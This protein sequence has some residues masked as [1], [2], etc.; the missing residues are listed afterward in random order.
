MDIRPLIEKM[1]VKE[2]EE[3]SGEPLRWGVELVLRRA[4]GRTAKPIEIIGT[5]LSLEGEPLAQIKV[6]KLE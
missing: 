6:I 2:E 4:K 5:I 1:E 3:K